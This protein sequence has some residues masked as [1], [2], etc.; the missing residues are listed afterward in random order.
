MK[1]KVPVQDAWASRVS[2][3][4]SPPSSVGEVAGEGGGRLAGLVLP[5]DSEWGRGVLWQA[6]AAN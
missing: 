1:V 5:G 3:L 2:P 4:P 6:K